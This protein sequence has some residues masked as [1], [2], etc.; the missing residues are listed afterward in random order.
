MKPIPGQVYILYHPSW[1]GGHDPDRYECLYDLVTAEYDIND[2]LIGWR[3]V[4]TGCA[5][6]I[7]NK[8]F[9]AEWQDRLMLLPDP[10]S[11]K[12]LIPT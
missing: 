4:T 11:K 8:G 9:T 1:S 3:S 5:E 2:N 7:A 10:K 6:P 12:W